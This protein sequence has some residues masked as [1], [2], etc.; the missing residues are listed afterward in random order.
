MGLDVK[1]ILKGHEL[2]HEVQSIVQV[3]YPNLHYYQTEE[4][5]AEGVTIVSIIENGVSKAELYEDGVLK[6]QASVEMDYFNNKYLDDEKRELKRFI[7]TAIYKMLSEYT[8]AEISWGIL[9]GIRP[10]KN[11]NELWT[12][13]AT[14]EEVMQVLTEKYLAKPEKIKLA[15]DVA[16]AEKKILQA[17][18]GTTAG[19]YIGIPFCPSRC[20]YC[21]FTS[22][23][24]KQYGNRVDEYLSAL[25]KEIEYTAKYSKRYNLESIY[26][27]GGTPTSFNETQLE[28]LLQKISENFD[29]SKLKEYTVEAG[30]PDTI[31]S[32]KLELLK[33]YG[34]GRIS[35]N[36]QTMNQKTL[37]LIGRKHTVEDIISVYHTARE[38]G[39]KNINMDLILGLPEETP[40]D[41]EYT[42]Q[43]IKKLNP[44]NVTVHTLAVKR[45]SRL[46]ETLE[47]YNFI[48]KEDMEEMLSISDSYARSMGMYPYYMYR[49]KNMVGNFENVGYCKPNTEGIY[50]IQIMEEK[51]TIL[52]AGAGS[53]TKLVY[54][55]GRI[56][57]IF[58][59]K[60]LEDYIS[61][62]DEM[63]DR[64]RKG[65]PQ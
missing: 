23:S 47:G 17:N 49:Q 62:I 60:S 7:K 31:T 11:V 52:S 56:E 64:K 34:V 42:M 53:T 27:G 1:F 16:K 5:Q 30:R 55:D 57:R 32:K 38:L 40:E 20:L 50:N 19:I 18:D 4:I 48:A 15:I 44:E 54:P 63:L 2:Y 8:K 35:I 12:K 65:L 13:G 41:V 29:I 25:I 28:I 43:E 61:R 21:S 22:F 3:F 36:P 46:K 33:Q 14:D 37:D 45:A 39:H 59:V 26:V 10:A 51:Q 9:T 6:A 58:N 24:L